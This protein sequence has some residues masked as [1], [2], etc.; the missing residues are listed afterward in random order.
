[1]NAL[2]L[3]TPPVKQVVEGAL[4]AAGGPLT[5]DQIL[6]LYPEERRPARDEIRAAVADLTAEYQERGIELV[7]VAGGWRIQVRRAVAPWVA[8]LWEEKPARYSRALLETLALI[9]YRQPITRG[10]IED[11]RGVAVSTQIVKTLT[12]REWI[13]VVGH[14]D[15]PGRPALYATTRRFLDYFGLRS[16]NDLPPLAELRDPAFFDEQLKAA[17]D[18]AMD[19]AAQAADALAAGVQATVPTAAVDDASAEP[20]ATIPPEGGAE[21]ESAAPRDPDRPESDHER[22]D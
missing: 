21:Q 1:M 2:S 14:R 20:L 18:A 15:V 4:M 13:R 16:L 8:R 6:G 22:P 10:E 9:A 12:E 3:A 7:E 5:L 11:I 19:A 17:G